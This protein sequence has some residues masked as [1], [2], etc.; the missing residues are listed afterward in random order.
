MISQDIWHGILSI[1]LSDAGGFIVQYFENE[2]IPNLIFQNHKL[3]FKLRFDD[4]QIKPSIP[5]DHKF[6]CTI[7]EQ[8]SLGLS[9]IKQSID[10]MITPFKQVM[11]IDDRLVDNKIN[12]IVNY[13]ISKV[14]QYHND[15][16]FMEW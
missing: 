16:I 3:F 10:E 8:D 2:G 6:V 4:E 7:I 11:I 9:F 12:E 5:S 1:F 14:A 15:N 13:L